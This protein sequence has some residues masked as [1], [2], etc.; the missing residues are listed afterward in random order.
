M[1]V[2]EM[3]VKVVDHPSGDQLPILLD[4]DGLPIPMPSEFVIARRVLATNTLIR[5]LRELLILHK[6]LKKERI[7]LWSRI[8][9]GKGFTEAEICGGLV[10]SLRR[11]Q[12]Q[13][14]TVKKMTVTL[15]SVN[16]RLTTIRQFLGSQFDIY[17]GSMVIDDMRYE[18][19]RDQKMRV[20]SWLDS[21]FI[22]APPT[23]FNKKLGLTIDQTKFLVSCLNPNSEQLYGRNPAVRFRNYVSVMIMLNYGLRPGE[24]L[25]LKVEDI[26]FGAISGIR[27]TRR[28]PNP[29]DE[30]RPR[31]QIKRNGRVMPIDDP[32][33]ARN[34]NEYI[35]KWRD[36]LEENSTV[37]SEYLILSDEGNPLSEQS[38]TQFFQIL[39]KRFPDNLPPNLTAKS[40]RHTF[41]S[42]MEKQLGEI[43]MDEERRKEA[44]AYLRGDSNSN[45]QNV[46][47]AQEIQEQ[48]IRSL[49]NYH[50]KIL[51]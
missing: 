40:L 26:E 46:Y 20:V 50:R 18:R 3:F 9:T 47:I 29:A 12:S 6:W 15:N 32:G 45:S 21:S 30:R 36:H 38:I 41:S 44:L 5:N 39:R 27:V 34:L 4:K 49:K 25:S 16:Q 48:A 8:S 11:D 17:L 31:P 22:N 43:G 19:I 28:K 1:E 51:G 24:L 33:F 10:E 37:E 7:D 42:N 23:N 35:M 2:L 14:R 13:Q